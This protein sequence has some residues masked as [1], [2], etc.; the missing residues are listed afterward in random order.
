M[1]TRGNTSNGSGGGDGSSSGSGSGSSRCWLKLTEAMQFPVL[2]QAMEQRL[3][4]YV[5]CW[6]HLVD[7]CPRDKFGLCV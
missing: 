3:P 1:V 7:M 5:K 4:E 6:A 2:M